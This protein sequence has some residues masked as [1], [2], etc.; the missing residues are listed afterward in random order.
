MGATLALMLG[1]EAYP[2]TGRVL[3]LGLDAAGKTTILYKLKLGEV[4]TTIPTIG[5]NVETVEFKPCRFGRHGNFSVTA[6]DVGGKDKI[7]PLWRHYFQDTQGIVFVVDSNDRERMCYAKEEL[8]H[9]LLEETLADVPVLLLANK[10]DLP[11]AL[12]AEE[13]VEELGMHKLM[14]EWHA[15]GTV[16]TTGVGLLDSMAWLSRTLQLRR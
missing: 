10:Q 16:A 13:V 6:W 4:V 8:E 7:R 3:F 5:F 11:N 14:R 9:L 1:R 2:A 12:T 15:E